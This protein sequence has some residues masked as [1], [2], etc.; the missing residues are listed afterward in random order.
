M[1]L[2][3][4][5]K[6]AEAWRKAADH[7]GQYNDA[8]NAWDYITGTPEEMELVR[9]KASFDWLVPKGASH[10]NGQRQLLLA[11]NRVIMRDLSE[12][13]A[14]ALELLRAEALEAQKIAENT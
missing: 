11:M 4:I 6:R 14:E 5:E 3:Q 10:A 8:R 7:M 1:D 13:V 9:H 12:L 2:E